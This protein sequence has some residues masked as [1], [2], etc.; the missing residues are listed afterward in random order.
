MRDRQNYLNL[1]VLIFLSSLSFTNQNAHACGSR[2]LFSDI[3][4]VQ[5][6][7]ESNDTAVGEILDDRMEAGEG[8]TAIEAIQIINLGSRI[9]PVVFSLLIQ[10]RFGF[11]AQLRHLNSVAADYYL[12][13]MMILL[14]VGEYISLARAMEGHGVSMRRLATHASESSDIRTLLS[15]DFAGGNLGQ[16]LVEG[17][18][19]LDVLAEGDEGSLQSFNLFAA[20]QQGD[21]DAVRRFRDDHQR[22][23]IA[24]IHGV[25]ALHWAVFRNQREI[26]ELL[27]NDFA[28]VNV[29]DHRGLTPLI[30][31]VRYGHREFVQFLLL[32]RDVDLE[33]VDNA[34]RTARDWA[35]AAGN[36]HILADIEAALEM[37]ARAGDAAGPE[38]RAVVDLL[39]RVAGA[40]G[41]GCG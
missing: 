14:L 29:R 11:V 22:T 7:E 8:L 16:M 25:T 34:G 4:L 33:A 13:D 9:A 3:P 2:A 28:D 17:R 12:N 1:F 32:N 24:P 40:V 30:Y 37:R 39:S 41:G 6:I 31:A 35:E 27:L 21:V 36:A 38:G 10:H 23:V 26:F 20:I 19:P 15:I 18:S 5:A